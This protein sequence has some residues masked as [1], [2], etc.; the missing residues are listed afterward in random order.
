MTQYGASF[1]AVYDSLMA[2][3]FDYAAWA[4]YYLELLASAGVR[5]GY[6]VECGCGTA[7]LGIQLAQRGI[8]VLGVD[9]SPDMLEIAARR[10]REAGVPLTLVRQDIA[11]LQLGRRAD[12]ILATD[13]C[14]NFFAGPQDKQFSAPINF[15]DVHYAF[16]HYVGTSGGNTDDMRAAVALMQEKKVQ[17]AKV[18]THILGLNAAGATT[19][20]LPAVGGGKKLVYTG[21][22][23]PLTPLGNISDPQLAAI[24]ERHH[25]I[26]SKEAEEYLLA[27]AEDIAH[28]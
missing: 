9:Q 11:L 4:N 20:D 5:P 10:A 26:W 13:G 7:S 6:L 28:D 24:M 1:A 15:Y 18:V 2:E 21:K 16:T 27:H 19:L 25:G 8:R 3:D 12:A 17:T 23:I 22:N 14:L